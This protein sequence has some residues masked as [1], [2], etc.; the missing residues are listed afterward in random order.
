[1]D[2]KEIQALHAQYASPTLTIDLAGQMARMPALPAPDAGGKR[3]GIQFGAVVRYRRHAVIA[4]AVAALAAGGGM[5]AARIWEVLHS[6]ATPQ[7]AASHPKATAVAPQP[8][9]AALADSEGNMPLNVAPPRPLSS[10]DFDSARASRSNGL[11]SVDPRTLSKSMDL[12][13]SADVPRP[14]TARPIGDDAAAA[15][16]PIH[17]PSRRVEAPTQPAA[18]PQSVASPVTEP[19]TPPRTQPAPA[20][21]TANAT[22]APAVV[23]PDKPVAVAAPAA[24]AVAAASADRPPVRTLRP[25]HHVTT[26]R[27]PVDETSSDPVAPSGAAT[28]APIGPARASD[29]QLF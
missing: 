25:L 10:S 7:V 27:K 12:A 24:P 15:A 23:S 22:I 8:Q 9:V 3:R 26:H 28:K 6:Q 2:L 5:S 19:A 17:A 21:T 29:V 1:M 20:R 18:A 14:A 4:L 16:S 11:A 13:P